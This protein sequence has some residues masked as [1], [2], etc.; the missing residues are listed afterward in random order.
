MLCKFVRK[1]KQIYFKA[2]RR[3][4]AF[5][6]QMNEPPLYVKNTSVSAFFKNYCLLKKVV[7]IIFTT[8]SKKKTSH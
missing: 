4:S 3:A 2:Y 8:S 6:M 1:R 5:Q 7:K